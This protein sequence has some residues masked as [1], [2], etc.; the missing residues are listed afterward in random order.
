MCLFDLKKKKVNKLA[1][2][3]TF[4][5]KDYFHGWLKPVLKESISALGQGFMIKEAIV[6]LNQY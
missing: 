4:M 2:L 3:Q 1:N 5:K 6:I